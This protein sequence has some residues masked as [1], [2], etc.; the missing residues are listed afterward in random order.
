[1]LGRSITALSHNEV[2]VNFERAV[3]APVGDHWRNPPYDAIS[4]ALILRND[5]A[6]REH[7]I[8]VLELAAFAANYSQQPSFIRKIAVALLKTSVSSDV[9]M[10]FMRPLLG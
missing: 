6:A 1:M 5:L 10:M 4:G 2:S 8:G 3:M 9:D 7:Q